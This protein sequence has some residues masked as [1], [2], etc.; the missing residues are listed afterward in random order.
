MFSKRTIKQRTVITHVDTASDALAVSIGERGYVDLD[1]MADLTGF[2]REKLLDDLRSVVFLNVSMATETSDL[3][4]SLT[5]ST[6]KDL[7]ML[8]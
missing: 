5:G 3:L 7:Y 4:K 1:Y 6:A 8:N 2:A